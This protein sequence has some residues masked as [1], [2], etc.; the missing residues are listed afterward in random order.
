ML[1]SFEEFPSLTG[2]PISSAVLIPNTFNI[3][4]M[5]LAIFNNNVWFTAEESQSLKYTLQA[6][7][8]SLI[9]SNTVFVSILSKKIVNWLK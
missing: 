6:D 3:S 2:N 1:T 9:A 8:H 7:M 5:Y 4:V